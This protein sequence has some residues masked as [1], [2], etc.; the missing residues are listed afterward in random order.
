MKSSPLLKRQPFLTP[1]IASL[2]IL[3][4]TL[5]LTSCERKNYFV[6]EGFTQGTTYRVIYHSPNGELFDEAI[7]Q[8]LKEVDNSLSVY[9]SNS[10]ISAI[11]RGEELVADTLII[12]V[13]KR[14]KEIYHLSDGAFD[15]SA[16]ALFNVWGFGA[17]EKEEISDAV[18]DSAMQLVGMEYIKLEGDRLIVEK[19]GVT[20]NFNAIAKGYTSD[21]IGYLL[22]RKG[23]D[24]FLVEVGGEI[25][26]KGVNKRGKAWSVGIERP[27]EGNQIQGADIQDVIVMEDGGLATSGNYRRFYKKE[28]ELF[29]HTIDPKSGRPVTHTLLSATVLTKDGMSADA[30]ATWFM[31]VGVE[32]AIEI[33]ESSNDIEAYLIYS[34]KEGFKIYK[35]E[36]IKLKK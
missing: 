26:A 22:E 2:T 28:G 17:G 9:N 16:S 23:S 30:Y 15:V 10:L 12:N 19:E 24:N 36:G 27:V 4:L 34:S 14:A 33:V 25:V 5:A 3:F 29:S 18:L 8:L 21:L 20:L 13:F 11:N 35:S 6:A 31:V 1:I 7:E 32:R